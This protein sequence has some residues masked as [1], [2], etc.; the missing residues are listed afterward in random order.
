MSDE[1]AEHPTDDG[2]PQRVINRGPTGPY[3]PRQMPLR[4]STERTAGDVA[5]ITAA[6][7]YG[8]A[9][10]NTDAR[11]PYG[12]NEAGMGRRAP[13]SSHATTLMDV[14]RHLIKP[15][16]DVQW[17]PVS[18]F[19]QPV[20]AYQITMA[21]DAGWMPAK[22]QH[23]REIVEPGTPDDAPVDRFG[24]RLFLRPLQMTMEAKQHQYDVAMQAQRANSQAAEQGRVLRGEDGGGV[25]QM[26]SRIVRPE[27]GSLSVEAEYGSYAQR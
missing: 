6:A 1:N 27:R 18:I 16:W 15:G 17:F 10:P 21:R 4:E 19:N 20:D 23:F 12:Y 5:G 24:Q 8:E 25:S 7:A 14:P 2:R 3:R 11:D 26:D 13:P 22:A 9:G